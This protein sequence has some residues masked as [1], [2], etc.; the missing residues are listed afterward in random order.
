[1]PEYSPK[2]QA[3]GDSPQ[4]SHPQTETD[5]PAATS[6]SYAEK[7]KEE[8]KE[9]QVEIDQL[10][11]KKAVIE[12]DA[13]ASEA[14]E[15]E[16]EQAVTPYA[17]ALPELTKSKSDA[18]QRIETKVKMIE[19]AIDPAKKNAVIAII[20]ATD[21]A[22]DDLE[23]KI[24][25]LKATQKTASTDYEA[26]Q[27]K[28][29]SA[30]AAFDDEKKSVGSAAVNLTAIQALFPR[31]EAEDPTHLATMYF[32]I[33]EGKRLIDETKLPSVDD[34]RQTLSAA[35]EN[36]TDK[37]TA[38]REAKIALENTTIDL[39]ANQQA[40]S[41]KQAGREEAILKEIAQYDVGPDVPMAEAA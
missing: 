21:K 32:L 23:K 31:I 20:N 13:A 33:M 11:K 5:L 29:I 30:Q 35:Y 14:A 1:V 3:G 34:V 25:G 36:L 40:L 38:A 17:D 8:A 15:N 19:A 37:M 10:T 22:I 24:E 4:E 7:L 18:E 2:T 6:D 27:A 16:V 39:E 28:L 41:E 26:A 12:G 9:L